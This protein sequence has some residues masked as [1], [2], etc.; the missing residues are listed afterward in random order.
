[1]TVRVNPNFS[2]SEPDSQSRKPQLPQNR[3][4]KLAAVSIVAKIA[5]VCPTIATIVSK[6]TTVVPDVACIR[7]DVSPIAS[8]LSP[9]LAFS[10][11]LSQV[12]DV[13]AALPFIPPQVAA[14]SADVARIVPDIPAVSAPVPR[15]ISCM[16]SDGAGYAG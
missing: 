16:R 11:V 10:P 13:R 7:P 12:A 5:E 3:K 8:Q 4:V 9:G 2:L 15:T 14:I 1:M 6:I